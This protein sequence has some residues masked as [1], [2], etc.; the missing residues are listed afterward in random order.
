MTMGRV[1][2]KAGRMKGLLATVLCVTLL[3]QVGAF[4]ADKFW[5]VDDGWWD[6]ALPAAARASSRSR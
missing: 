4:A 6:V 1:N 3:W 5:D 2:D